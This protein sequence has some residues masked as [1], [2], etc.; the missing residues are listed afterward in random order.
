MSITRRD[1]PV[2]MVAR[3]EFGQISLTLNIHFYDASKQILI[4]LLDH[5]I[6]IQ[7]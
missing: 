4:K 7:L 6:R 5:H 1:F 2:F 3:H